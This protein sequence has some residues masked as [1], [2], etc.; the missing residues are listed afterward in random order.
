MIQTKAGE[1]SDLDECCDARYSVLDGET[2]THNHVQIVPAHPTHLRIYQ[3][4]RI[5]RAVRHTFTQ[6]C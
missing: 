3:I 1:E 5:T 4:L 6:T 2:E